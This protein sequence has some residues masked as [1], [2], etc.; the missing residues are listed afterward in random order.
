MDKFPTKHFR[1]VALLEALI[2]LA[3]FA[4]GMVGIAQYQG[5][6]VKEGGVQKARDEATLLAQQQLDD[7]RNLDRDAFQSLQSNTAGESITGTNAEFNRSW[8][9]NRT[10]DNGFYTVVKLSWSAADGSSQEVELPAYIVWTDAG[11]QAA[12]QGTSSFSALPSTSG[13]AVLN[14][15][16]LALAN[17]TSTETL[18]DTGVRMLIDDQ[19][20]VSQIVDED[21]KVLL[22]T[23]NAAGFVNLRG[24]VRWDPLAGLATPLSAFYN[25]NPSIPYEVKPITSDNSVCFPDSLIPTRTTNYFTPDPS[26]PPDGY[27]FDC[28]VSPYWYGNLAV[29]GYD[30]KDEI[31]PVLYSYPSGYLNS[32]RDT[33]ELIWVLNNQNFVLTN[34][35]GNDTCTSVVIPPARELVAANIVLNGQLRIPAALALGDTEVEATTNQ[36]C[37]IETTPDLLNGDAI[38]DYVCNVLTDED[39]WGG[40][41]LVE[42]AA[43]L[44]VCDSNAYYFPASDYP[45]KSA[46]SPYAVPAFT[47]RANEADCPALAQY[48]FTVV[49]QATAASANLGAD[50]IN[51]TSHSCS[52]ISGD[53]KDATYH[54]SVIASLGETVGFTYTHPSAVLTP[55][56]QSKT[57]PANAQDNREVNANSVIQLSK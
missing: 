22:Q 12:M 57:M 20:Q 39:G 16:T 8:Y 56:S 50:A 3:I 44:V 17:P 31:C 5:Y 34:L 23:N 9:I 4:I 1:G 41:V 10:T 32:V 11:T 38:Y 28:Y 42:P 54:C 19:L 2:A 30:S 49:F 36:I 13:D 18:T 33:A 15:D 43:G 48:E 21:N 53:K 29:V 45:L 35:K 40:H 6:V 52:L 7:F 27:F 25:A 37:Q 47:L 24:Y 51:F 46:D 26:D 55:S 14:P